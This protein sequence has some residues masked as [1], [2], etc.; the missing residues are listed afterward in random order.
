MMR[1]P[2]T[3]PQPPLPDL[4]GLSEAERQKIMAV[5][6]AAEADVTMPQQRPQP[7]QQQQHAPTT[8]SLSGL[9]E[10]EQAKIRAV[11]AAAD[12]DMAPMMPP[13][14]QQP[15][16]VVPQQKQQPAPVPAPQK[17]GFGGFGFGKLT[18]GLTTMVKQGAD[19]SKAAMKSAEQ[20]LAAVSLPPAPSST[21]GLRFSP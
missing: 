7:V 13:I 14:S 18:S 19:A 2:S 6:S 11:M 21:A 20:Q 5:M 12:Q 8:E 1:P 16:P 9:T 15:R 4:S 17:S 3:T 10:A